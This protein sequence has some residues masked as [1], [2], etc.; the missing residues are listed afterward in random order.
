MPFILAAGP[1][2]LV[3]GLVATEAGMKLYETM[4]MTI[5]VIGGASQFAALAQMQQQ[6]PLVLVIAAGLLVNM[7]M[8]IYSAAL[9]P[10]LGPA[11]FWKRAFAAYMLVDNVYITAIADYTKRPDAPI[12]ARMRYFFGTALP[13]CTA[14]YLSTLIGAMAGRAIPES[15]QLDFIVPIA[16]IALL[17]P[18]LRT[19]AHL[20]AVMTSVVVALLLAWMPYNTELLVA[21]LAAMAAGAEVERRRGAQ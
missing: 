18:M 13:A 21:A 15:W 6:A 8:A 5:L 2:G 20:T 7:R 17:A 12:S 16:F 11:P 4:A 19:L 1:F 14:W 9:A 3:F 10:H